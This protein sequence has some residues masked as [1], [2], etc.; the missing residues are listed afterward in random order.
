MEVMRNKIVLMFIL[1]FAIVQ[2]SAS[3]VFARAHLFDLHRQDTDPPIISPFIC[4][5]TP[6]E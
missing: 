3:S 5:Y 2:A 4:S 1:L 6:E